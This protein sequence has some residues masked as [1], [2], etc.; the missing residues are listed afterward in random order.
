MPSVQDFLFE[1]LLLCQL[2]DGPSCRLSGVPAVQGRHGVLPDDPSSSSIGL[3]VPLSTDASS[4][5]ERDGVLPH[6][7]YFFSGDGVTVFCLTT[8]HVRPGRALMPTR[9]EFAQP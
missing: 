4:P 7:S 8:D 1:M 3:A 2:L 5:H 9:G 6:D